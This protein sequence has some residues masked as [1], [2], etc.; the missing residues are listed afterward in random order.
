MGLT[1]AVNVPNYHVRNLYN[2]HVK[3]IKSVN[4]VNLNFLGEITAQDYLVAQITG[5]DEVLSKIYR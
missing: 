5:K 1:G 2:I 3:K 4:W